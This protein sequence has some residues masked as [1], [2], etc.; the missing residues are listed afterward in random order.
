MSMGKN[1]KSARGQRALRKS[2]V[3]L[4]AMSLTAGL[5]YGLST[6]KTA[7]FITAALADP[8]SV[9]SKRSP[10]AR[11]SAALNQTKKPKSA[12]PQRAQELADVFPKERVLSN[13]R[14]RAP[15]IPDGAEQYTNALLTTPVSSIGDGTIADFGGLPGGGAPTGGF[16]SP[17]NPGGVGFLPGGGGGGGGGGVPITPGLP[18]IP[19]VPEPTTWLMVIAG[20]FA[21]GAALRARPTLVAIKAISHSG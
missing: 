4:V 21:V 1:Y 9:L 2:L 16:I 18:P 19:A 20:L 14:T 5:G 3:V 8:L 13:V 11:S 7:A 15:V 10:G 6:P 12:H 17:F